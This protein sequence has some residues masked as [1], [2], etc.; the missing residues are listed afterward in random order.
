MRSTFWFEGRF[1]VLTTMDYSGIG[2][3]F[4]KVLTLDLEKKQCYWKHHFSIQWL[5]FSFK[6]NGTG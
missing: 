3:G 2:C 6:C 5:I 4:K 1:M